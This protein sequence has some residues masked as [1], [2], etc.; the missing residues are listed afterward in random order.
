[1]STLPAAAAA[2]RRGRACLHRTGCKGLA[3]A[4]GLG[5]LTGALDERGASGA[6]VPDEQP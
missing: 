6:A 3:A 2:A 1:L 4:D 5:P